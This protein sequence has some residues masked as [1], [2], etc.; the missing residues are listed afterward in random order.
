MP[1]RRYAADPRSG[2]DRSLALV[3]YR[4]TR[5][6]TFDSGVDADDTSMLAIEIPVL[7]H[8]KERHA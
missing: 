8:R 5:E 6:W 1:G 4:S 7:D 3:G 2:G